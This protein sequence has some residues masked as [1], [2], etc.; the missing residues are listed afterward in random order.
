MQNIKCPDCGNLNPDIRELGYTLPATCGHCL[1]MWRLQD[2]DPHGGCIAP[3]TPAAPAQQPEPA[4]TLPEHQRSAPPVIYLHDGD[5]DRTEPF[6]DGDE[7]GVTW[8]ADN[9][10]SAGVRYLRAD[11][12]TPAQQPDW[13]DAY[14]HLLQQAGKALDELSC[15]KVNSAA[16]RLRHAVSLAPPEIASPSVQ[17]RAPL[18]LEQIGDL[19]FGQAGVPLTWDQRVTIVR[20]AERAHGITAA[21]K[22]QA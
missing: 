8:S 12:A 18:T 22:E 16:D 11:I 3:P 10:T 19:E 2:V 9:A 21:P 20:A 17:H 5:D 4:I 7:Y 6:P 15:V 13:K 1:H 14:L